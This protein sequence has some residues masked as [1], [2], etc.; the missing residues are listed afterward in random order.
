MWIKGTEGLFNSTGYRSFVAEHYE[1]DGPQDPAFSVV[2]GFRL[3]ASRQG[4]GK[5]KGEDPGDV[6]CRYEG[7]DCVMRAKEALSKISTH[8]DGRAFSKVCDLTS[9]Y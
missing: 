7:E 5:D 4:R 2:C 6:I 1:A 8:L 3:G 9:R